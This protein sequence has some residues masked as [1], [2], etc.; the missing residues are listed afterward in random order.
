VKRASETGGLEG[1]IQPVCFLEGL[2][3]DRDDGVEAGAFL[4]KASIRFR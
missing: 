3:I 1:S 4:S 2:G